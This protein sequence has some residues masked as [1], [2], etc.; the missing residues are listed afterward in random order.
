MQVVYLFFVPR[1]RG[2]QV[3]FPLHR[4]PHRGPGVSP[5]NSILHS[6]NWCPICCNIGFTIGYCCGLLQRCDRVRQRL[7][8]GKHVKAL[9]S[10]RAHGCPLSALPVAA[11][12]V[13]SAF[14]ALSALSLLVWHRR[15]GVL[16]TIFVGARTLRLL[17]VKAI[18]YRI[19]HCL[20][21][22]VILGRGFDPHLP[23]LFGVVAALAL[24]VPVVALP[25]LSGGRRSNALSHGNFQAPASW[26]LTLIICC[27]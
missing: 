21:D 13:S 16:F 2:G 4:E 20:V 19:V 26:I 22:E 8:S 6:F 18:V 11:E 15:A 23:F 7:W 12:C 10:H 5:R 1:H 14:L 24:R 27:L 25:G 3:Q 9:A 17:P